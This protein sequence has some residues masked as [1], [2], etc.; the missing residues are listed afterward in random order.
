MRPLLLEQE[1]AAAAA[2]VSSAAA[3]SGKA[4]GE[5]PH[6]AGVS[7]EFGPSA[8]VSFPLGQPFARGAPFPAH[9]SCPGGV[10]ATAGLWKL[11]GMVE[12]ILRN[13]SPC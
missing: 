7:F 1:E 2:A 6:A 12:E 5:D 8:F 11:P 10:A 9:A 4:A 3:D 13:V